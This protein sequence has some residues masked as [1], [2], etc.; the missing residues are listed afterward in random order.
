MLFHVLNVERGNHSKRKEKA[1]R[2]KQVV[3]T[4]QKN[5]SLIYVSRMFFLFI[6]EVERKLF[7]PLPKKKKMKTT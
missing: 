5:I 4:P 1:D 2:A 7:S 6:I 3:T